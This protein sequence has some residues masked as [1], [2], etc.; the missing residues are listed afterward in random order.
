MI[1]EDVLAPGL[2]LVVCGSAAGHRSARLRQY[3]A[4]PG[5]KFWRT[6]AEV[7]LTPRRLAPAEF[8]LLPC[9]GIGLTDLVQDQSGGDADLD[10][11][12]A[13]RAELREKI[14]RLEP[15][16]LCFNGKRAAQEFLGRKRVDYG[17]QRERIGRTR[18]FV[19]PS[20][21]GAASGAWDAAQWR[22]L[23]K[24]AGRATRARAAP[25]RRSRYSRRDRRS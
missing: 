13:G 12:R 1:L 25:V 11:A 2:R 5:N 22:R 20:T 24:L 6:L 4:G 16:L 18:L 15:R 8:A 17:L 7:A 10:F 23:A 9:W 14:L 19:A 21:S 3:Y